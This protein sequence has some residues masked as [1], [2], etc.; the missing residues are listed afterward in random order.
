MPSFQTVHKVAHSSEDMFALVA[1]VEKYPEFVPLCEKL[2]VRGRKDLGE[3]REVLVADMTVAYKLF[4]ETFTSRVTL[5]SA[6]RRI[7][8]EYLDGPFRHLE[9]VWTFKPLGEDA[10]EVGFDITYEFKSRTLSALMSAMFDRA[11]RKFSDAFEARAD[12]V[13]GAG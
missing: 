12:V 2:Q 10:C 3:G 7:L 4:R 6:N 1:D 9:N 11:F 5:E 8:V 13:Y